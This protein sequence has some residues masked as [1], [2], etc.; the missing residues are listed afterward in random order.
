MA[1]IGIIANPHSKLNRRNPRRQKLLSYIA[2]ER[3]RFEL[4]NDLNELNA[5]AG[6]FRDRGIQILAINGG[7][8]TISRTLSAFINVYGETPLPE[9]ALLRGGTINMLADNLGIKGTPEHNLFCL[10]ETHSSEEVFRKQ[11]LRSMKIKD[12]YGFLFANGTSARFLE[13]F[14]KNK[15]GPVGSFKLI[16]KIAL[17]YLV[18]GKL[19]RGIVRNEK[20]ALVEGSGRGFEHG[21]LSVLCS[22]VPKMPLGSLLF[23]EALTDQSL[24]QVVS[25]TLSEPELV[26]HIIPSLML[27]PDKPGKGKTRF[28]TNKLKI[29]SAPPQVYTLDGELYHSQDGCIEVGTGPLITFLLPESEA[30]S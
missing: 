14:Y 28:S 3:G 11:A 20:V 4:T 26:R 17:S 15:T 1:G 25:I 18:K 2:G 23:P 19:Y 24:F 16:G 6:D 12:D 7:D 27:F 8:G 13:E 30:E 29:S 10:L 9:I 22:T 5:V 21:S